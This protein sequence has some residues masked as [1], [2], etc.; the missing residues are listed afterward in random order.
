VAV[1]T[2]DAGRYLRVHGLGIQSGRRGDDHVIALEGDLEM[3]N[4]AAIE[5]ELSHVE[6][7]DCRQIVFDLRGLSFLDST[8]IH[9]LMC[10]HARS[11]SSGRPIALLVDGGPVH[12]VL[13]A[14]GALSILPTQA[15]AA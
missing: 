2:P 10:A 13:N 11:Q 6:A 3:A 4:V 7:G 1:S 5:S 9:L 15:V 14:C 8:G 12:R